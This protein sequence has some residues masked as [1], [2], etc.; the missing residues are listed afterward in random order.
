MGT[1][2]H[3]FLWHGKQILLFWGFIV[4]NMDKGDGLTRYYINHTMESNM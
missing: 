2:L 4:L 1:M 3:G